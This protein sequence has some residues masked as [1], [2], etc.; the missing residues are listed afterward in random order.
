M[1]KVIDLNFLRD[2]NLDSFLSAGNLGVLFEYH[3]M[4]MSKGDS[5]LNFAKSLERI[6][7]FP[8]NILICEPVASLIQRTGIPGNVDNSSLISQ[9]ATRNFGDFCSH[10]ASYGN[11][12]AKDAIFVQLT[13]SAKTFFVD[14]RSDAQQV[15]SYIQRSLTHL[16]SP[17]ERNGLRTDKEITYERRLWILKDAADLTTDILRQ[18]GCNIPQI[19]NCLAFRY[20]VAGYLLGFHWIVS[21]GGLDQLPADKMVN[22]ITDM[23]YVALSTYFDGILTNEKKVNWVEKELVTTLQYV[24]N[25]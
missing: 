4:E 12:N 16:L 3:F 15:V 10:V 9:P 21:G 7:R 20:I 8:Q 11:D 22:D 25:D 17:D 14:R 23:M 18:K 24:T 19:S 6:S 13:G 5:S 2:P 1:L